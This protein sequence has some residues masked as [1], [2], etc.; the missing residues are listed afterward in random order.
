LIR[1]GEIFD[2]PLALGFGVKEPSQLAGLLKAPDAV[3]F[4][5]ALIRHLE[6]GGTAAE[7]MAPWRAVS[8]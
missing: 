3:I 6:G 8:K 2:L 5:S 4:G 7:F 1:A